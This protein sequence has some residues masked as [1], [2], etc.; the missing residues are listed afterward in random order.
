[1]PKF[2]VPVLP[3]DSVE[4]HPNADRLSINRIRGYTL[5]SNKLEDGSHRYKPGQLVQFIPL[6]SHVPEYIL[7][8]GY[9][10]ET[11]NRGLL[12]GEHH[13][14]VEPIL[15][16]KVLSDGLIIPIQIMD[17][18][19]YVVNAFGDKRLARVGEN[20]AEFIGVS[21]QNRSY[22]MGVV[23]NA[24]KDY[25]GGPLHDIVDPQRFDYEFEDLKMFPDALNGKQVVVSELLH[26]IG[27]VIGFDR[28]LGEDP[29]FVA[30]ADYFKAYNLKKDK[31]HIY[32]QTAKPIWE[33]IKRY[34]V[35]MPAVEKF[36]IFGVI[37]GPGIQDLTYG[38]ET[39]EFRGTDVWMGVMGG[40][41]DTIPDG[42]IDPVKKAAL[43][44]WLNIATVPILGAGDFD[45]SIID[46]L[47]K[48][49]SSLGGGLRKGVVINAEDES[50]VD[51]LR[52]AFSLLS[53]KFLLRK[54]GTNWK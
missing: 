12:G 49:P 16:R 45:R 36:Y 8:Q 41:P 11:N 34:L 32:T 17:D 1:M 48:G 46:E 25:S 19:P 51:G 13:N 21:P 7:R 39:T 35:E 52:P 54:K 9:W 29:F 20:V 53:N 42:F 40:G 6:N 38:L 3:I 22:V 27:C 26:G 43:F 31:D 33:E 15:L 18:Q 14:L 28:R 30:D 2:K 5:V 10:D 4:N 44:K 23:A 37:I 50:L 47:L 24:Q